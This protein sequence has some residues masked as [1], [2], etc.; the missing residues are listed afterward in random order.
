M[1]R[2]RTAAWL[3]RDSHYAEHS[4]DI[5]ETPE[6][7]AILISEGHADPIHSERAKGRVKGGNKRK[8]AQKAAAHEQRSLTLIERLQRHARIVRLPSWDISLNARRNA[9][10]WF[11]HRASGDL[12]TEWKVKGSDPGWVDMQLENFHPV[13][14]LPYVTASLRTLSSTDPFTLRDLNIAA[15]VLDAVGRLVILRTQ[16]YDCSAHV[17][18]WKSWNIP[19][20][21]VALVA[22]IRAL[23]HR[24]ANAM[25]GK[26][27]T[28]TRGTHFF[29]LFGLH[30][31]NL[32]V[33]LRVL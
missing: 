8:K 23:K 13:P 20:I 28:H 3:I 32:P 12:I 4:P 30:R 19:A 17:E 18:L 15:A 2:E 33:S 5:C 26:M 27:D 11:A 24:G 21:M 31:N 6:C 14:Y 7:D 16:V 22:F 10:G 9:Q 1:A 25:T 29:S